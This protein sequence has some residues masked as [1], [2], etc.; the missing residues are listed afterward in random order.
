MIELLFLVRSIVS[1]YV[2][3]NITK[4]ALSGAHTSAE[5]TD[6]AECYH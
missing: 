3:I 2:I 5:A 4:M 6:V 1:S